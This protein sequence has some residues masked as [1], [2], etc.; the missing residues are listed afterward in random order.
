MRY[1]MKMPGH[2]LF[3]YRNN[4]G[5][6]IPV[7]DGIRVEDTRNVSWPWIMDAILGENYKK[8]G[9]RMVMN[10]ITFRDDWPKS[11]CQV[12][13]DLIEH[14]GR[15]HRT[16]VKVWYEGGDTTS[17]YLGN[18]TGTTK[19]VM[20]L[21][22]RRSVGGHPLWSRIVRITGSTKDGKVYWDMARDEPV[23]WV[24]KQ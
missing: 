16:R 3:M 24:M 17:G 10:G 13:L 18:S 6:E 20:I 2:E 15:S 14:P 5:Q 1:D 7:L 4:K 23:L 21:P 8:Y 22:N 12:M 19:I 9:F 11:L